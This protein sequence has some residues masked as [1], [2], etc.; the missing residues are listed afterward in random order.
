MFLIFLIILVYYYNTVISINLILNGLPKSNY[1][2]TV[3][4]IIQIR[5]KSVTDNSKEKKFKYNLNSEW[6]LPTENNTTI[7]QL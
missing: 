4:L 1:L 7:S 6:K 5:V 2:F 3:L